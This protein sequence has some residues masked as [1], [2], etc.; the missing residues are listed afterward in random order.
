VP[1]NCAGTLAACPRRNDRASKRSASPPS[2]YCRSTACRR[3]DASGKK[4]SK[5][6]GSIRCRSL[7]RS[8][9]TRRKT[10]STAFR[11]TVARLH[12]AG[13]EGLIDVRLNHT[14]E[15]TIWPDAVVRGYRQKR[16]L[17]WLKRTTRDTT[18][19]H[20]ASAVRSID[21]SRV[22]QMSNGFAALWVEVCH[23]DGFRFDWR[24]TG[25]GAEAVLA[26]TRAVSDGSPAG[27]R[28]IAASSSSTRL[29]YRHGRL[30]GRAF[31]SQ[32]RNGMTANAAPCGGNGVAKAALSAKSQGRMDRLVLPD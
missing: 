25:A 5:L 16:I 22:L 19:I 27:P 8:R 31:R 15:G 11:T 23:V 9:A 29:G 7:P 14:A 32:W 28:D 1:P 12:D 24:R 17:Y 21:P 6:R 3:P 2:S 20:W 4:L 10:R 18:T 13:I 26:A 30:S